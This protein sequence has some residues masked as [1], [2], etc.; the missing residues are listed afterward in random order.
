MR[1]LLLASAAVAALAAA[2]T[3]GGEPSSSRVR[4]KEYVAARNAALTAGATAPLTLDDMA[5][6]EKTPEVFLDLSAPRSGARWLKRRPGGATY[7]EARISTGPVAVSVR[8]NGRALELRDG[9][10]WTAPNGLLLK[11]YVSFPR[12]RL[13]LHDPEHPRRKAFTGL[14]YYP[15]DP[16]AVVT[17]RF[18]A[19]AR[20]EPYVSAT[21]IG[22]GI[23]AYAVGWADFVYAGK[24]CRLRVFADDPDAPTALDLRF[25]DRTTG[26]ETYGGGRFLRA[27][28]RG[29][30]RSGELVL[31]FNRAYNPVCARLPFYSCELIAGAPLP[32][33]IRAGEKAPSLR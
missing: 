31:D 4:W 33:A 6:S 20:P 30:L 1:A 26:R 5:Y 2:P 8:P 12:I 23:K 24:P 27:Q 11:A 22:L 17:S 19:D 32:V 13:A 29:P 28:W 14:P 9:E 3:A 18:T 10:V 15:Y 25:K 21:S 7:L 16:R